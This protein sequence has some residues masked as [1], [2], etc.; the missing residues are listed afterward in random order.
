MQQ[1]VSQIKDWASFHDIFAATPGFP[2]FYGRNMDAWIDCLTYRDE[3]DG[4]ASVVVP[5]GDVLTLQLDEGRSFAQRCPEQ[6]AALIECAAFVNWRRIEPATDRFSPSPSGNRALPH[7]GTRSSTHVKPQ[8]TPS[9]ANAEATR[10]PCETPFV[11]SVRLPEVRE[12]LLRDVSTLATTGPEVDDVWVGDAV[13]EVWHLLDP[14]HG[15]EPGDLLKDADEI[16]AGTALWR[17]LDRVAWPLDRDGR[18][19]NREWA[20]VVNAADAFVSRCEG[21]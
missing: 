8:A 15:R 2:S 4:M 7:R 19:A 16:T 10:L 14:S 17:A 20:D 9:Q 5:A 11:M 6:Y 1:S 12:A 3:D 18:A 21:A 13:E